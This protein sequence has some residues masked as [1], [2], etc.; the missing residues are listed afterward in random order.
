MFWIAGG[1]WIFQ[2]LYKAAPS[3]PTGFLAEQM[4]HQAWAGVRFYDLIFPLFVFIVGVSLVFSLSKALQ[5][6]SRAQAMKRIVMRSLFLYVFGLLVYGGISKGWE[7]VRW[8]GV[9]QRIAIAYCGAGLLFCFLKPRALV[10]CCAS[11]LLG[12]WALATF[13][14][15]RDFNLEKEHLAAAGL[16]PDSPETKARFLATTNWVTGKFE[17]GLNL[18]QHLDYLYLPGH[19]WD[20]AY[21]PE[22]LLSTMGAIATC[23]LGVFVGLLLRNSPAGDQTKVYYLLGAGVAGVVVGYLWGVQFPVIKKI[24]TSSYVLVAAGYSC[25]MLAAFY[26][27]IEIW[28]W[29]KWCTPFV[30][31]GTNAITIYMIF[32]LLNV[33]KLVEL[34]V[35]GPIAAGL[36]GWSEFVIAVVGVAGMLAL[37]RFLYE[38][39][40]FLRL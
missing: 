30:W 6:G 29:R 32:H 38:R 12:Y 8:L 5:Q 35:G 26:Q 15:V 7:E 27:M 23:L 39:K 21:D 33:R 25:L 18:P 3:G 17:D 10:A 20:G 34:V 40:I 2:G 13:V 16:T 37:A 1:E 36:G 19:R 28:N 11:L 14:P 4:D 9:L 31:I 22:G 24:W